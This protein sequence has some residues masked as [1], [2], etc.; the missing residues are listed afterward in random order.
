MRRFSWIFVIL[1]TATVAEAQSASAK[2]TADKQVDQQ[3]RWDVNLTAGFFGA[4]PEGTDE[5]YGDDWY[6]EGRYAVSG[7][8]FWTRHLKTELEFATSGEADRYVT[9]TIT[10]P[11]FNGPYP[12]NY[13]E[14]YRLQQA[15]ARVGWQF[16]DNAWVH[17]YVNAGFVTDIER[18]RSHLPE[19]FRYVGTDAR[20]PANRQVV[21]NEER[22]G[23][24]T[25]YRHGMTMGG[26]AK[27]FVSP[28]MYINTGAQWTYAKSVVSL[29]WIGG[30]GVEF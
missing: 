28:S 23:P 29:A 10:V 8:Y 16:L 27:F 15:S 5:R 9:R 11:G 19:Q 17:P 18:L 21:A 2:A 26:G 6:E 14:F 12:L 7:G 1:L 22:T 3:P 25:V 24:D 20:N 4:R 30:L 13:Q